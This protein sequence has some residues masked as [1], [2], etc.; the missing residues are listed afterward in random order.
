MKKMQQ[1]REK[2]RECVQSRT[3][4]LLNLTH[5]KGS[6]LT[7]NHLYFLT[8]IHLTPSHDDYLIP[9]TPDSARQERD[10]SRQRAQAK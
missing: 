8:I 9:S 4:L 2:K 3:L 7:I 1:I 10:S 6:V 5:K